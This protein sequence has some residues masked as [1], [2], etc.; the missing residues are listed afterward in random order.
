MFLYH[1]LQTKLKNISYIFLKK[2][3]LFKPLTILKNAT[4]NINNYWSETETTIVS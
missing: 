1:K 2:V 4:C 3:T